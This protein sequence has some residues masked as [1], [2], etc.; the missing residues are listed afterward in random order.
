M[1]FRK[2][3]VKSV[4]AVVGYWFGE[5]RATG[6]VWPHGLSC[7][8]RVVQ[9]TDCTPSNIQEQPMQRSLNDDAKTL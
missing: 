6:N 4:V 2:G 9:K 5:G 7:V 8:W 1:R 3:G